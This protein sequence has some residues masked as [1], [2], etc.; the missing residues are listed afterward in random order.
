MAKHDKRVEFKHLIQGAIT[1]LEHESRFSELSRFALGMI[2]EGEK[3][4]RFQ[5]GL[6]PTIRNKVVPLAIREY[7]ELVKRAL[8]VK[9]DIEDINQIREQREDRKG[10]QKVGESSQRRPQNQ[11]QR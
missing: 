7:F 4:R 2:S 9:Q 8:L 10:K 5:Q 1:V 3:V 11:Q 6:R